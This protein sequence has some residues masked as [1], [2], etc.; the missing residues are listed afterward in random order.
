MA[1]RQRL[2]FPLA[3][4]TMAAMALLALVV[5]LGPD[6]S[7]AQVPQDYPQTTLEPRSEVGRSI[8]QL[9]DNIVVWV[10][11]IFVVVETA[12]V[13]TVL[14]FRRRPG[15]PPAKPIHGNT[16]LEIGWTLA[17]AIILAF[18][19][20]PTVKTIFENAKTTPGDITVR[21]IGHQWWWEFQY[22]GLGVITA[23]ELHL[24]ANKTV[25]F[26]LESA[27]VIHSF[28]VPAFAGK[29]D[30]IPGRT[31]HLWF[32]PDGTGTFPGQCAEFCGA[33]HAN[34]MFK[35]IVEPQAE[36]DAWVA[37]QKAPSPP[38]DST[39][40]AARGLAIYQK[41]QCVACHMID[42]VSYGVLG[43]NLTKLA[44]R[45]T[46]ASG[47]FPNDEAHLKPWI[48]NAPA[49]KPG[50]LMLKM[51]LSDADADAVVAYLRTRR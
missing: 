4:A 23:N 45:S 21:V 47:M 44:T 40:L 34:M 37:Q 36:F 27:D 9:L 31:N 3:F 8:D 33:S 15:S 14:R 32:T 43:P 24:P 50:S 19:A 11:I 7:W 2:P 42:G 46:I 1:D 38:P 48:Q 25:S 22:P 49:K 20:V 29:K 35:V 12:L 28:W 51:D 10:I 41:S 13:V 30:L 18:I 17:P 39:S 26:E 5:V 16:A 6:V